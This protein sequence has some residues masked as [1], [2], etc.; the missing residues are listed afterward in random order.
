MKETRWHRCNVL[1][2]TS[3]TWAVWSFGHGK[4]GPDFETTATGSAGDPVPA[5]LATRDVR[6]LWRPLLNVAWLPADKVFLRV[7]EVPAADP[8]EV[9]AMVEFELERL[10]PLPVAD[11]LWTCE[12]IPGPEETPR[13]VA[14][15]IAARPAVEEFLGTLETG[16][17]VPDRLEL[18]LLR[19]LLCLEPSPDSVWV[20]LRREAE[21][22]SCL[23]GWWSKGRLCHLELRILADDEN[24]E[25]VLAGNLAHTA[26]AGEIGGWH[27]PAS[28]C[29]L[30]A[31]DELA[32]RLQPALGE[33][34]PHLE[35]RPKLPDKE[36]AARSAAATAGANLVPP[37][38]RTR[39]RQ[40]FVDRLWM[41]AVGAVALVYVFGVLGFFAAL[42]IQ[43]FRKMRVDDQV[44]L[45]YSSYTNA[46]A[47][48]AR[49][50]VLS[51]QVNLKFAALDCLKA[52]SDAL[53]AD[54]TLTSFSFQRGN[55]LGLFGT[56]PTDL[57]ARVTEF[58]ETLADSTVNG[59]PL[60]TTVS[61]KAIQAMPNRPANWT[62]ECEFRRPDSR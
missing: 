27:G 55:R 56:V 23:H 8:S 30:V 18:P 16:G 39:Y 48:K 49:V 33:Q 57:Q 34:F 45:L 44:G 50:D 38:A 24:L 10:S 1:A 35:L 11:I 15:V 51:D 43:D 61:T 25:T 19:E 5:R 22:I 3:D 28:R 13:T 4:S 54:M 32:A 62:I 26:W 47:L 41:R 6:H 12:V 31:D 53:P 2:R 14:V 42:N 9:P 21:R 58:T 60:F 29:H 52:A 17:F 36:L 20:L 59:E 37:E 40:Q 46:L 7:V